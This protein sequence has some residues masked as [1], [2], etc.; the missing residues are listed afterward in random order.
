MPAGEILAQMAKR[1]ES[2]IR[3]RV[4]DSGASAVSVKSSAALSLGAVVASV[5]EFVAE[6]G[7]A[8]DHCP[9]C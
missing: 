9:R 5:L 6:P 1:F 2:E 3:V 4:V 8:A 7:I